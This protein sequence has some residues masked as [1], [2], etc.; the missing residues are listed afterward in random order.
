VEDVDGPEFLVAGAKSTSTML[1]Q[2]F[3]VSVPSPEF[4]LS[5]IV[6]AAEQSTAPCDALAI[7]SACTCFCT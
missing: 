4:F 2:E 6:T 5:R 1:S 7:H 3:F